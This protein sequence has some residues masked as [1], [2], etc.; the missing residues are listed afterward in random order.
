MY[1]YFGN[2]IITYK[3]KEE[4]CE[5]LNI[6]KKI[7]Q[8]LASGYSKGLSKEG[9]RIRYS[10]SKVPVKKFEIDSRYLGKHFNFYHDNEIAFS[11]VKDAWLFFSKMIMKGQVKFEIEIKNKT[12]KVPFKFCELSEHPEMD[13]TDPR[14]IEI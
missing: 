7:L 10:N 2:Y 3:N 8:K 1:D 5:N 4:A 9:I 6:A 13:N 12:D 11:S 14:L